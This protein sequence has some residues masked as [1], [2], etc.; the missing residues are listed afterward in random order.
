M[1][2]SDV[3]MNEW[4]RENEIIRND[5]NCTRRRRTDEKRENGLNVIS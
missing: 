5:G 1:S 4:V 2:I 3:D